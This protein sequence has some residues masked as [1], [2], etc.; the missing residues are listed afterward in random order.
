MRASPVARERA[1]LLFLPSRLRLSANQSEY[2]GSRNV[3]AFI[4]ELAAIEHAR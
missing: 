4:E 3:N 1:K 2:K